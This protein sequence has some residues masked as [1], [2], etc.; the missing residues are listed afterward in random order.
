MNPFFYG[1]TAMGC[2][3]AGLFFLRFWRESL[4]RLFLL[5]AL[6]FWMLAFNYAVLGTVAFANEWR[7]YVF[8]VRLAAFCLIIFAIVDKNRH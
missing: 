3:I 1:A 7:V 6:A 4:D 5:F 2:F 8:L